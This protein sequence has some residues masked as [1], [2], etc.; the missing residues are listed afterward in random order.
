MVTTLLSSDIDAE[1]YK[2]SV[3]LVFLWP[4]DTAFSSIMPNNTTSTCVRY[5]TQLTSH[6]F[7]CFDRAGTLAFPSG[8]ATQV[9]PP[10]FTQYKFTQRVVQEESF[11]FYPGFTMDTNSLISGPG[12]DPC[13]LSIIS[14]GGTQVAIMEQAEQIEA[15]G[16][17]REGRG[18]AQGTKS[19][20]DLT[21]LEYLFHSYDKFAVEGAAAALE[22][23]CWRHAVP[24]PSASRRDFSSLPQFD[25]LVVERTQPWAHPLSP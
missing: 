10:R 7:F 5:I 1:S 2:G 15:V 21:M 24:D 16:D 4:V 22:Q 19:T 13:S 20:S 17:P 11:S 3:V 6:I 9:A 25:P 14:G 8:Q 18:Q 23:D 12:Q